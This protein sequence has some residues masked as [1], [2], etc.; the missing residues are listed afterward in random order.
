MTGG[1][2]DNLSANKTQWLSMRD[3]RARRG[4]E[5]V[6]S[7]EVTDDFWSRVESL[8]QDHDKIEVPLG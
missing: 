5:K 7:M 2:T 4:D 3:I 6:E 1:L 8:I